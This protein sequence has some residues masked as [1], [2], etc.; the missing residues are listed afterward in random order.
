MR[1]FGG[2]PGIDRRLIRYRIYGRRM[3]LRSDLVHFARAHFLARAYSTLLITLVT[4]VRERNTVK[5]PSLRRIV[6]LFPFRQCTQFL[7]NHSTLSRIFRPAPDTR[8]RSPCPPAPASTTFPPP[9]TK[10]ARH[11]QIHTIYAIKN[12]VPWLRVL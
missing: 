7:P 11:I 9:R 8:H 5:S 6:L 10:C 12:N 3:A 2:G 4:R 1:I